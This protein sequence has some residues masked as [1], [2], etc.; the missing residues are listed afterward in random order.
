MIG[1]AIQDAARRAHRRRRG[2]PPPGSAPISALSADG[3]QAA[4][5]T[6]ADLALSPVAVSRQGFDAAGAA[7]TH[8]ETLYT[9]KRVRQP[10]PNQASLTAAGVALSDYVYSTDTISGVTNNSTEVSPKPVAAWAVCD[11]RIVGNALTVSCTAFH[12]NGRAGKPVAC[13]VFRASDGANTVTAMAENPAATVDPLTGNAIIEYAATLDLTSLADNAAITVNAL[14]YPRVG[15]AASV[16]DSADLSN[17]YD[18]S[19]RTFRKNT[20][21]A[22]APYIVLVKST[23][24]DSTG[25][26]DTSTST[27][28][29]A[30]LTLTGAI[31]R[32]RAVLGTAA[33]ALDGVEFW[34]DAGTWSRSATPTAN[35]VNAAIVIRPIPGVAKAACVLEFGAANNTFGLAHVRITGLTVRRAGA[36]Y[37]NSVAGTCTVEDCAWDWNGN[38]STAIGASATAVSHYFINVAFNAATSGIGLTGG[39]A[40]A[41]ALV[42]GC[43]GGVANSTAGYEML[44][45][46]GN[47]MLGGSRNNG[48]N[49]SE[50]NRVV[51]FN[52]FIAVGG[53]TV[54]SI[55]GFNIGTSGTGIAV[56]QNVFEY[57]AAGGTAQRSLLPSGDG[58]PNSI[59]HLIVWHNTF[60]G[61]AAYGRGNILYDETAGALGDATKRRQHKLQSF[62]GNIHVQI[63]TKSDRFC[64]AQAIADAPNRTGN[65]A[66]SFGVGCRG[67]FARYCD[68][69][70][71]SFTAGLGPDY[72]GIGSVIGTGIT[73]AGLDPLFTDYQA[74]ASGPIAGPGRGTYT[75]DALSPARGLVTVSPVPFDMVGNP[76]SGT[77]AAGAYV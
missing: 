74:T 61:F 1:L 11:R 18:F 60:A 39:T 43:T 28:K 29:V 37:L 54:S 25:A 65:W 59:S 55:V 70:N 5:V 19:P 49:R 45:W 6:P 50:D 26:V 33:G 31:N 51:A 9:T 8:N 27:D 10:Y 20:A 7:T 64:G 38:T 44:C 67:E 66:Y 16:L 68:A 46:I 41:I 63:N 73:D 69:G 48:A 14:V 15:L 75:I 58:S 42:R 34:L 30:C 2:T 32:A 47:A 23:G 71:G 3:W 17:P 24:N 13:V 40:M 22:A 12:R 21:R 56:V 76:R 53:A 35:T 77:V 4:M 36:F 52:R 72:H 57:S 62:V